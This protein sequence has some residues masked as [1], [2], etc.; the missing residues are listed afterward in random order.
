MTTPAYLPPPVVLSAP[1]GTGKTTLAR[2]LVADGPGFAFSVSATTRAPRD[3]ERDGIDY[4]FVDPAA[5]EALAA[6]GELVEW[7]K[8]HGRHSYGTLGRELT[9]AAERG[10]HV[11]LDIDVQGA[12]QIR[13]RVPGAVLIFVLPPSVEALLG[14][15]TGRG[16]EDPDEVARRLRS[17]R[18]EL[19]AV[20]EFDYVVV[21]DDL[22]G[23]LAEIRGIL[24]AEG[25]RVSRTP[26]LEQDVE[27]MRS[28]IARVL[29]EQ[30]YEN[31]GAASVDAGSADVPV[32]KTTESE[33]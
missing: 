9:A 12:R 6:D 27:S 33:E 10:E 3:G 13:E 21:N 15:L 22:E 16:T 25:F 14:R 26:G 20:A 17:A 5:F 2:R 30:F 24:R 31:V 19:R 8:V 18:D 4:H 29:R 28:G 23:C 11:V 32:T 1:A 7:A